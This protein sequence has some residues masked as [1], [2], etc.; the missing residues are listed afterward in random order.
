[1]EEILQNEKNLNVIFDKDTDLGLIYKNDAEK[2]I[3]IKTNDIIDKTMFKIYNHLLDFYDDIKNK[4][5]KLSELDAQK[6]IVEKKF[7]EFNNDKNKKTKECVKNILVDIFD[8]NK[9][10][11]IERFVQFANNGQKSNNIIE[12]N[13]ILNLNDKKYMDENNFEFDF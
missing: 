10:K 1:M 6:E 13:N 7:E 9:D 5:Y 3:N 2:F 8:K 4:G 11:V 12:N